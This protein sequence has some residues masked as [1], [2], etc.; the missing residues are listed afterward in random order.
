M[1]KKQKAEGFLAA[2]TEF[3]FSKNAGLLLVQTT[4]RV[5]LFSVGFT[6]R[7]LPAWVYFSLKKQTLRPVGRI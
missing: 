1:K 3:L 7:D 2:A 5:L 6:V 4:T